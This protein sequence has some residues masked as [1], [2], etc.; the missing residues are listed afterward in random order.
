MNK[1]T[2]RTNQ[3]AALLKYWAD[4]PKEQRDI[5]KEKQRNGMKAYWTKIKAMQAKLKELEETN[6]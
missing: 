3:K 2:D 1:T 6:Q 5:R 4:M